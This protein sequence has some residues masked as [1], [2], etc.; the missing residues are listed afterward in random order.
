VIRHLEVTYP[1]KFI[2]LLNA[3]LLQLRKRLQNVML[4]IGE[5]IEKAKQENARLVEQTYRSIMTIQYVP[6]VL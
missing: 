3:E 4:P 1:I 2:A 6:H 5:K